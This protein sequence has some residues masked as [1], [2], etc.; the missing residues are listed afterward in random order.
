MENFHFCNPARNTQ[1]EKPS[2]HARN[3]IL[4]ITRHWR[5][6]ECHWKNREGLSNFREYLILHTELLKQRL[7]ELSPPV[8]Y[9]AA[10]STK[11]SYWR[12]TA[13]IDPV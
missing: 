4:D 7:L 1:S 6:R 10:V 5:M 11:W 13:L 3:A 2:A 9:H 12:K 8:W